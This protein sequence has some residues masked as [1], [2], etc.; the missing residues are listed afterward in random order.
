MKLFTKKLAKEQ[1]VME[2]Q[3]NSQFNFSIFISQNTVFTSTL[4]HIRVQILYTVAHFLYRHI[5][6][7]CFRLQTPIFCEFYFI[8]IGLKIAFRLMYPI[9]CLKC[10]GIWWLIFIFYCNILNYIINCLF[11]YPP[12]L[13]YALGQARVFFHSSPLDPDLH[14][15]V[16]WYVYN[17]IGPNQ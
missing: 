15:D 1:L 16:R 7:T 4:L 13:K 2:K 5:L 10:G 9:F 12:N 11:R 8:I 6:A 14:R 17:V 3:V